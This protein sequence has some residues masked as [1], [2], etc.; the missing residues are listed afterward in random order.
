M[1]GSGRRQY[2]F[3]SPLIGEVAY[4]MVAQN[5]RASF[6]RLLATHLA[7]AAAADPGEVA[8]HFDWGGA[9]KEAARWWARAALADAQRGD[10]P[11]VLRC[12]ERALEL[13]ARVEDLFRLHMARAEALRFLLR[14]EE[15]LAAL[16]QALAVASD[17]AERAQAL[18]QTAFILTRTGRLEEA[19]GTGIGAVAAADD[20]GDRVVRALS[21]CTLAQAQTFAGAYAEAD[22]L[23]AEAAALAPDA[24]PVARAQIAEAQALSA[25][26]QGDIGR[27][28]DA[29]AEA[30]EQYRRVGH[31]REAAMMEQNVADAY[32]RVGAYAEADA[33]L[34]QALDGCRR[35]KNR[36]GEAYAL[37]NLG[38]AD[39]MLGK[40]ELALLALDEAAQLARE[41]GDARLG[42]AVQAY[43]ARALFTARAYAEAKRE[44]EGAAREAEGAGMSALR[45]GALAL[46]ADA[47]LALSDVDAALAA[48]ERAL[49]LRDELGGIE[50]DEA[51]VFLARVRALSAAERTEE[52]GR[53][54]ERG[55]ARLAE[56]AAQITDPD[57]RRR[58]IEQVPA[59][60]ALAQAG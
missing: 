49:A 37:T 35:V 44:A 21:R 56:V 13:D 46:S 48:S 6:H 59:H 4:R 58:F 26:A 42:V 52:A 19:I 53:V 15:Q 36:V 55:M 17:D 33:A 47:S 2:S 3:R 45:A 20:S 41:M 7:A 43:R 1:G 38:Y 9:P 54:R 51:E 39:A 8:C 23:L 18:R 30:A 22:A 57:F 14:R 50:E 10:S 28:R 5:A 27:A 25:A 31:V 40:A 16:E 29:F 12:A 11:S 32:N 60:G 24:G 34:R